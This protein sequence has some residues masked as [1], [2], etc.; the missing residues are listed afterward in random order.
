MVMF[1]GDGDDTMTGSLANGNYFDGGTGNDAMI[2]Q[3]RPWRWVAGD[4]T[5]HGG[6]DKDTFVDLY[7]ATQLSAT[8][9]TPSRRRGLRPA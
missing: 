3:H 8:T 2:A 7:G 5:M 4:D 1:G 9:A 6:G